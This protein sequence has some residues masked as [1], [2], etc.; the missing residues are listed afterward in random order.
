M[1]ISL[2]NP[3]LEKIEQVDAAD[4]HHSRFDSRVS[5]F[6]RTIIDNVELLQ[7][8]VACR[9]WSE[10]RTIFVELHDGRI[11]GFPASRFRGLRDATDEELREVKRSGPRTIHRRLLYVGGTIPLPGPFH[12]SLSLSL[13]IDASELSKLYPTWSSPGSWGNDEFGLG[14]NLYNFQRL[15]F[16]VRPHEIW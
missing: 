12:S 15:S 16:G 10:Q 9:A 3:I 5:L 1:Q 14:K 6:M 13:F 2:L 11:V 4:S 7:E 8:P